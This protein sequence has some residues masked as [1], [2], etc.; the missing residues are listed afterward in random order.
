MVMEGGRNRRAPAWKCSKSNSARIHFFRA[1]AKPDFRG[2][3]EAAAPHDPH[4]PPAC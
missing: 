1:A 3:L 2:E 4:E